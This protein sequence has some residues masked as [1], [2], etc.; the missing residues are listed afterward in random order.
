MLHSIYPVDVVDCLTNFI[1]FLNGNLWRL[2][3]K[4]YFYP[5]ILHSNQ[6]SLILAWILNNLYLIDFVWSL[7][8][9]PI[10]SNNNCF[11]IHLDNT[12]KEDTSKAYTR[13]SYVNKTYIFQKV[14]KFRVRVYVN[15]K[16]MSNKNSYTSEQFDIIV[17]R[18][19]NKLNY[20]C[21]ILIMS[22]NIE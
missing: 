7:G 5:Y 18:I 19:N 6:R 20:C 15:R 22:S 9:I 1:S 21:C 2:L 8:H 17:V 13:C 14:L 10:W 3:T 4:R 12:V 11:H 16:T